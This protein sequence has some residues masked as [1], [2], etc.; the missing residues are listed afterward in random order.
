MGLFVGVK[1]TVVVG[2]DIFCFLLVCVGRVVESRRVGL[3]YFCCA[4][5]FVFLFILVKKLCEGI[6]HVG[7]N[8]EI[9]NYVMFKFSDAF[10]DSFSHINILWNFLDCQN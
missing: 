2:V 5:M 8:V 9:S 1:V 3:L 6:F 10:F 4:W 7:V